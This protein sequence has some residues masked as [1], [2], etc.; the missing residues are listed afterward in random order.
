MAMTPDNWGE[1]R[2]LYET[3]N[4]SLG[5]LA[6]RFGHDK[7][8]FSR[9]K[10]S[11]GW[12]R[13]GDLARIAEG[14]HL[15]ADARNDP[16]QRARLT[17]QEA[18]TI[19]A[20]LVADHREQWSGLEARRTAAIGALDSALETG[21]PADIRLAKESSLALLNHVRALQLMQDG[22][23]KAWGLDVLLP[24]DDPNKSVIVIDNTLSPEDLKKLSDEQLEAI[25]SGRCK[26]I[27]A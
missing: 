4:F 14:A 11:E 13:P 1:A 12:H 25:V 27:G 15:R 2:R 22:Q 8:G 5:M 9:R 10:N 3:E 16:E 20:E 23:R 26:V 21:N 18:E 7:S 6:A 24:F 17:E 19:R